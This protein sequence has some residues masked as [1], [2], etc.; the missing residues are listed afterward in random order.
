MEFGG[1]GSRTVFAACPLFLG[2]LSFAQACRF[3][4][5]ARWTADRRFL[6]D[7]DPEVERQVLSLRPTEYR[8]QF[9]LIAFSKQFHVQAR[10]TC[11]RLQVF[12]IAIDIARQ[13]RQD[14]IVPLKRFE[15]EIPES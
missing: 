2:L 11:Q 12:T 13:F 5:I 15:L 7:V 9:P 3:G 14:K 8:S 10:T 6:D 4:Q 1:G